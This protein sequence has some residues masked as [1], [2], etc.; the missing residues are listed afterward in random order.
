MIKD[1]NIKKGNRVK[2]DTVIKGLE[3][4]GMKGYYAE[5]G[6]EALKMI[7]EMMPEGS[8]VGRGGSAT[9]NQIGV[10]EELHKRNYTCYEPHSET[11]PDRII[12]VRRAIF[13]ADFML[14][15]ANAITLDGEI[16]NIDG[17]GNRLAP[18]IYGPDK[19]IF[20]ISAKKIA[21]NV[22]AAIDRVKCDACPPNCIRLNKN[23]P[24]AITGKCGNC[25]SPGNT[26]CCNTNITRYNSIPDRIHVILVNEDLGF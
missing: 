5:D 12:A 13:S 17:T 8:S 4:R 6:E 10:F 11:D 23:T 3:K 1:D 20:I 21:A 16:V 9:L 22:H 15:S 19:V 14:T 18:I 2:I 26:V 25:L 7:L 24:C